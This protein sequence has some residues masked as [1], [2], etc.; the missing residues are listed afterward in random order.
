MLFTQESMAEKNNTLMTIMII[1]VLSGAIY[2]IATTDT[3][4]GVIIS[5]ILIL[6]CAVIVSVGMD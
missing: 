1:I 2:T 5:L 3:L 6:V 4:R